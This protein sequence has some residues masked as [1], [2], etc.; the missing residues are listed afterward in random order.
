MS[1]FAYGNLVLSKNQEL[2]EIGKAENCYIV[3]LNAKWVCYLTPNDMA[4]ADCIS[5]EHFGK[6]VLEISQKTPVLYFFHPEDHGWGFGVVEN[7]QVTSS[8]SMDYE[9][10]EEKVRSAPKRNKARV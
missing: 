2:V 4:V 8:F 6:D 7:G 9:S 10:D 1:S 3:S 5:A